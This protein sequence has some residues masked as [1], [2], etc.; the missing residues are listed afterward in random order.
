MVTIL[1]KWKA[2]FSN[3]K[4]LI[5]VERN[6]TVTDTIQRAWMWSAKVRG[7]NSIIEGSLEW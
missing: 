2:A 7:D 4:R 5:L 3:S 1:F 6:T